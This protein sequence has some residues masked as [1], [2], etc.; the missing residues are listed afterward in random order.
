[1]AG[2]PS[3]RHGSSRLVPLNPYIIKHNNNNQIPPPTTLY[4]TIAHRAETPSDM[5]IV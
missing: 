3:H 1:M 2:Y 4:E 5:V